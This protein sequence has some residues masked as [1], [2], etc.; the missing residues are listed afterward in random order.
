MATSATKARRKK[1]T[2]NNPPVE[3]VTVRGV[4]NR[5]IFYNAEN[6]YV[7]LSLTIINDTPS[8]ENYLDDNIITAVGNMATVREGDEYNFTGHWTNSPKYGRQFKFSQSE[9]LLPSSSKGMARYLS[10]VTFGVGLAKAERIIEALGDDALEKIK[11]NPSVLD[12]PSLSFL[13]AQQKE[14]IAADLAQNSVQ[15]EL[16]GMIVRDGIGMGT[17]AKIMAEY[18]ENAVRI[19]KENPYILTSLYGMGF[20]TAD[21]IAQG[22]GIAPNSPFRVEAAI[23]YTLKESGNEGHVYLKPSDIVARLIHR[24][25][26]LEASGVDIPMI[27]QA[28]K[29]NIDDGKCVREGDAIYTKALYYAEKNVAAAIRRLT[30]KEKCKIVGLDEMISLLE[31][32][33]SIEYAPEQ[34]KAITAALEHSISVIT[35][36][37]GTGKS[38]ITRAIVEIY[39]QNNI[40]NEIYLCAP[41]GRAA[42]R[43]GEA[44]GHEGKTIHRLLGYHPEAGGFEY[45]EGNPLPGPGLL[46]ADEFSMAD[47]ELADSLLSAADNLQVI[48]VGDVDQLPSV[49]PGSVLRDIIA[50]GRVLTTRLMFNY[51]Q[52]GGSKIAEFANMVCQ[53]GVPVLRNEGDFE[54]VMVEDGDQGA[55]AIL[56]LVNGIVSEGYGP[57]DWQVLAPMRRGTCGVTKL[58]EALRE[59]VN[60]KREGEPTLGWYRAGDKVMVIKNHYALGVFNG[61][62][63]I[64]KEIGRG[65]MTV[66]FSSKGESDT[67]IFSGED[68]DIL[69]LAYASTI[70]KSQGSEFPIVIMP[71]VQSHYV[72]LQRNLLYT[73]I[74]RAKKWLVLV[75]EERSVK[76][77]VKNDVI[78]TRF[79]MLVERIRGEV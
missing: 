62:L 16:A 69:T 33:Y 44:T 7:V 4:V 6:G 20:V 8:A 25:G 65:S 39:R 3:Q 60:P 78:K 18:G 14:D 9:L 63:G 77:A 56:A 42:K 17:V 49:G 1:K 10:R 54:F 71:L 50:S 31:Q 47:I 11:Q 58:N 19:V 66:D 51:R 79:S 41:T 22:V 67:V 12:H 28:N 55:Q 68:L 76:H 2:S 23:A 32:K 30:E 26:L 43:L 46:I 24:K 61:D 52:A 73:G 57:L 48:L 34:R 59:M 27:A 74:T 29:K 5:H 64:V 75:A 36:G 35:G 40:K 13:T 53:G 70:H 38:E 15:A 45:R 21:A 72:M 37:P